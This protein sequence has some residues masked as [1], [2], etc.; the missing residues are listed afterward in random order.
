MNEN[1]TLAQRILNQRRA[2][3]LSQGGSWPNRWG[4]PPGGGQGEGAARA[5]PTWTR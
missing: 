4:V 1:E 5:S 2:R 3:G